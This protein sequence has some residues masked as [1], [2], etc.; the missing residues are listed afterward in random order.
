MG[1]PDTRVSMPPYCIN[2]VIRDMRLNFKF[3]YYL[4]FW[5][6]ILLIIFMENLIGD[7]PLLK[8]EQAIEKS[9]AGLTRP[10]VNIHLKFGS[11]QLIVASNKKITIWLLW[12]INRNNFN[13]NG[14]TH[15][16]T[17][18]VPRVICHWFDVL[19]IVRGWC[20]LLLCISFWFTVRHEREKERYTC[21]EPALFPTQI[22]LNLD[23]LSND[24]QKKSIN[25]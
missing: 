13:L 7:R 25:K 16:S 21:K 9:I 4:C 12:A 8:W 3:D 20:F 14:G 18:W 19:R 2:A 22:H 6:H 1:F 11:S 17:F 24:W 10:S 23:S 5:A 15:N